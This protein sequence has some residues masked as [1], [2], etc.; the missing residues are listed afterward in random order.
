L[1]FGG[2]YVRPPLIGEQ[3][4][5]Q[6]GVKITDSNV[7]HSGYTSILIEGTIIGVRLETGKLSYVKRF[8][9]NG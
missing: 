8:E 4:N 2:L 6:F 3:R 9:L 1:A 7:S 5:D